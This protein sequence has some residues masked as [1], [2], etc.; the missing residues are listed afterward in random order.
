MS[1]RDWLEG[2]AMSGL[3]ANP[4]FSNHAPNEIYRRA[5]AAADAMLTAKAR[6]GAEKS[7]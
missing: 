6:G 5:K 2:V 7:P 1:M 4:S 3:L